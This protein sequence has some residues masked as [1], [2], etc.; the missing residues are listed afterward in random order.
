M[1]ENQIVTCY[2]YDNDYYFNGEAPVQVL[3]GALNLPPNITDQKPTLKEGVFLKFDGTKWTEEQEPQ[4]EAFLK[5]QAKADPITLHERRLLELVKMFT[6][7]NKEYR[8]KLDSDGLYFTV[9]K[10]PPK[11]LEEVRQEKLQ[12][13]ERITAGFKGN[14]NKDMYFTSSLGF[15]ANGDKDALTNSKTLLDCFNLP[16]FGETT[17]YYDYDSKEHNLNKTQIQT[18]YVEIAMYGQ[19]LYVARDAFLEQINQAKTIDQ[20]NKI[21]FEF[22]HELPQQNRGKK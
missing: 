7:D 6:N 15:K 5:V 1:E 8:L 14:V 20:L 11:T 17:L 3:N 22:P 10:V 13:L 19:S 9:E 2:Q 12:E 21:A 16:G 18:L 4:G